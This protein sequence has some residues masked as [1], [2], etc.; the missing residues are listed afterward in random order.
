MDDSV[1]PDADDD[2]LVR[3]MREGRQ[4]ALRAVLTRYAS[5]VRGYLRCR[6]GGSLPAPEIDAALN[7]AACNLWRTIGSYD[8]GESTLLAWFIRIA[9]NAAM[10]ELRKERRHR[11]EELTAE[12]EFRPAK[13]SAQEGRTEETASERRLRL[14]LHVINTELVGNMRAVALADVE[15]GGEADRKELA[16]RLGIPV[17]QVDVTRSQTRKRIRELVERLE[18]QNPPTGTGKP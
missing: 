16:A 8:S 11:A 1:K 14:M 13:A 3:G 18:K 6:F 4:G 10:D 9:H 7:Q 12:P 2:E 17:A 15:A 5:R